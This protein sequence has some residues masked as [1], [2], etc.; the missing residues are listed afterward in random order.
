MFGGAGD[1]WKNEWQEKAG[2]ALSGLKDMV[3]ARGG[4]YLGVYG[5]EE[6]ISFLELRQED[7]AWRIGRQAE[8]KWQR[9]EDFSELAELLAERTAQ[10]LTREG[11]QDLPLALCL[12]E[13]CF[14]CHLFPISTAIPLPEQRTAAYWEM[15]RF[16]QDCGLSPEMVKCISL[17]LPDRT[18]MVE[19]LALEREKISMLED[20]FGRRGCPLAGLYPETPVLLECQSGSCGWQI[21]EA[22]ISPAAEAGGT[23]EHERR[24]LFAAAALAGLGRQGWPENLLEDKGEVNGWNYEGIGRAASILTGVLL[25]LCLSLDLGEFFLTSRAAEE[26]GRQLAELEPARQAMEA[27]RKMIAAAEVK[28]ACL[29]RLT[30]KSR[31]LDSLL[32]HLGT[33]TVEGAWLT[34]VDCTEEKILHLRG[35]AV[36]YSALGEFLEAFE[37]DSDFFSAVPVLEESRQKE[38]LVEFRLKVEMGI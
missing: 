29:G 38:G 4:T 23:E 24:P 20:A 5:G 18:D 37:R 3:Y 13:K 35:E 8:E 14:L 6:E 21:G 34:E 17:P 27:D 28:E 22:E 10:R 11:W 7:G 9:P 25:I 16:L 2:R 15:D 19:A 33:V 26:A 32:I 1:Q 36:D 30:E 12:P 31:P